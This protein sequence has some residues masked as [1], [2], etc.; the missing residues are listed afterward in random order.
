MT[1]HRN[2]DSFLGGGLLVA[3][4]AALWTSDV[5]FRPGLAKTLGS[6]QVVLA[7]DAVVC[8]FLLPLLFLGAA[9][10][11]RLRPRQWLA[12][13]VIGIGP[14]AL[15]T[16]LF[17]KALSF[18]FSASGVDTQVL[19]EVYLLYLAQPIF[20]IALAW[21]ILRERRR[22]S[23]WPPAIGALV[24]I[25]LVV[26]ADS[27][28]APLAIHHAELTGAAL[29]LAAVFLWASGTVLGRYALDEL[30]FGVTAALRFV[31][32]LPVLLVLALVEKGGA[33]LQYPAASFLP[34]L[35]IALIPGLAAMLLYYRGLSR[36]RASIASIAEL[37]YPCALFLLFSLPAPFG[38]GAPL[39]PVEILGA[40]V[41][42]ASVT[43]VNLLHVR[44]PIVQRENEKR[45]PEAV[46]T[47]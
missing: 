38:Q 42:V 40:I 27:P 34:I 10:L 43:A 32:A 29:T 6:S 1:T 26:F 37:A 31:I 8:V 22:A 14:Q 46:A 11:R 47:A 4:A 41:L 28:L 35:G 7:E 16:V 45:T 36:T 21:L 15:A 17:T 30:S 2:R 13:A 3:V 25:Y 12:I 24:G 44:R 9:S 20:G 5:Y 19:H 23:F 33:A 18:A 39:Q